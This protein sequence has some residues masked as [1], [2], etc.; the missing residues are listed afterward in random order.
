VRRYA[1]YRREPRIAID[2][3]RGELMRG[4]RSPQKAGIRRCVSP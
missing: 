2:A 1:P 3:M 4:T